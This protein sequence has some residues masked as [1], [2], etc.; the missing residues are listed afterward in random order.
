VWRKGSGL[1]VL[2][3]MVHSAGGAH[4]IF[5]DPYPDTVSKQVMRLCVES[6]DL[7]TILE[8][9]DTTDLYSY[10]V[11]MDALLGR[12][13]RLQEQIALL[14]SA[15]TVLPPEDGRYSVVILER[16]SDGCARGM[17]EEL[18]QRVRT[19]IEGAI[20]RLNAL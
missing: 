17:H 6:W 8:C 15:N 19:L 2:S 14:Q 16:I 18:E 1:I 5:D 13:G 9:V 4:R 12:L 11:V 7:V 3:L 20:E 10:T